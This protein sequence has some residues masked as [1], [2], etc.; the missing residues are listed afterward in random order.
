M[1]RFQQ[2]N[3]W[4]WVRFWHVHGW[5]RLQMS[6]QLMVKHKFLQTNVN[7]KRQHST[8]C[9]SWQG[10]ALH[11]LSVAYRR[12]KQIHYV[13]PFMNRF[14]ARASLLWSLHVTAKK[15]KCHIWLETF[16]IS[17]STQIFLGIQFNISVHHSPSYIQYCQISCYSEAGFPTQAVKWVGNLP[18]KFHPKPRQNACSKVTIF[19]RCRLE[20]KLHSPQPTSPND[21]DDAKIC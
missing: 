12:L 14:C 13:K 15:N 5:C 11:P 2:A 1:I 21:I 3:H 7:L 17:V 8:N 6:F 10:F 19:R 4:I 20:R 18:L 9:I 16:P